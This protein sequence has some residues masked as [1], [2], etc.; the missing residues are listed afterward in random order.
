MQNQVHSGLF[1]FLLPNMFILILQHQIKCLTHL[2][3]YVIQKAH[4][5]QFGLLYYNVFYLYKSIDSSYGMFSWIVENTFQVFNMFPV[6][7]EN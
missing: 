5:V 6:G 3:E 1:L 4:L 7:F 2:H